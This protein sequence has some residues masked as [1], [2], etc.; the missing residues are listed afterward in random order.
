MYMCAA[1][2]WHTLTHTKNQRHGQSFKIKMRVNAQTHIK[3]TCGRE[4][5]KDKMCEVY[6]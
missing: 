4:G 5:L 2:G 1:D 3:C 6:V